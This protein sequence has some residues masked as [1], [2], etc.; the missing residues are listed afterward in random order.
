MTTPKT[1]RLATPEEVEQINKDADEAE[2][3]HFES[4]LADAPLIGDANRSATVES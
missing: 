4:D 1:N 3:L 2:R